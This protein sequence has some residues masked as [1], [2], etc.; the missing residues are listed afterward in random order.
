[1]RRNKHTDV[2]GVPKRQTIKREKTVKST[3]GLPEEE[4]DD[5]GLNWSKASTIAAI[6][7]L[8]LFLGVFFM[9]DIGDRIIQTKYQK[10]A[11]AATTS[12]TPDKSNTFHIAILAGAKTGQADVIKYLESLSDADFEKFMKALSDEVSGSDIDGIESAKSLFA[13]L[14][15]GGITSKAD[16]IAY[17]KAMEP[18]EFDAFI[19]AIVTLINPE[20][21]DAVTRPVHDANSLKQSL[22]DAYA[23]AEKLYPG[24]ID[25]SKRLKLIAELNA[26]PYLYY[27][28][29]DGDTLLALSKSFS[30]SLGQLVEIN[31]IHDADVIAAGEIL[32]FPS[33]TVQPDINN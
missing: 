28:A 14:K 18:N 1:M 29:E 22:E 31:G 24:K 30:V 7:G 20:Q 17:L 27:V 8:V 32:L 10:H 11:Y 21:L 12:S 23:E 4:M 33:D 6:T 19:K 13:A 26:G 9:T 25:G 15:A 2:Q 16:I 3:T 5:M